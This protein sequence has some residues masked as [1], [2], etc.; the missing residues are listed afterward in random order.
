MLL[1]SCNFRENRC[2]ESHTFLEGADEV[3]LYAFGKKFD[4]ESV[5]KIMRPIMGYAKISL[6]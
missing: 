4:R 2:S 6:A 5:Q 3:T 1:S